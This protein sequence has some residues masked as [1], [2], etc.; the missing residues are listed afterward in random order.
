MGNNQRMGD[1]NIELGEKN[2]FTLFLST[3]IGNVENHKWKT[4]YWISYKQ[5]PL[6]M[7]PICVFKAVGKKAENKNLKSSSWDKRD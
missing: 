6:G 4:N 5:L 2:N 7:E 1:F 3:E